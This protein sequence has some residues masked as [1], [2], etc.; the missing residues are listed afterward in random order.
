MYMFINIS[1]DRPTFIIY[2]YYRAQGEMYSD[3]LEN[4]VIKLPKTFA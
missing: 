1:R 4:L 2:I 3:G